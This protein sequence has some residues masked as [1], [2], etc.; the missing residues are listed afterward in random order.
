MDTAIRPMTEGDAPAVA[1]LRV[2][3]WRTAY[4]GLM[5]AEFLAGLR[6]ERFVRWL[7]T[8]PTLDGHVV[9]QRPGGELLG[10][11]SSGPYRTDG[12][13]DGHG[14][15][16]LYALYVRPDAWGGGVGRALL[17]ASRD[18]LAA[19]G[20]RRVRLWVVVGNER[21]QRFYTAAG[22]PPDGRRREERIGETLVAEERR[23]A[24][25]P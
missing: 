14:D 2:A 7:G 6:P 15:G 9:A 25:L 22:L 16:E 21:A 17:A 23:T 19:R 20:H 13:G 11:A 18:R 5:P 24:P 10:W 3:G 4:R 8:R 12:D 1:D